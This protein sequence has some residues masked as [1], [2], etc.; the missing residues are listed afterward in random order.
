MFEYGRRQIFSETFDKPFRIGAVELLHHQMMRIFVIENRVR[1][2]AT[3]G[4]VALAD[5][6]K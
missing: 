3:V 4:P 2:E 6:D 5:I 1:A